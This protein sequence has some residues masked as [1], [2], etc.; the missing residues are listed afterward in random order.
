LS[1][2][3]ILLFFQSFTLFVHGINKKI[4]FLFN[5]FEI[6]DIILS[7]ESL[8]FSDSNIRFKLN[9]V[10]LNLMI[11][12]HEIFELFLCFSDFSFKNVGLLFFG[13]VNFIDLVKFLFRFDSKSLCDIVIVMCFFVIHL[14][15]SKLLLRSVK[16]DTDFLFTF[17]N[18]FLFYFSFLQFQFECLFFFEELLIEKVLHRSIKWVIS[19][20]IFEIIFVLRSGHELF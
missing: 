15:G 10:S 8:N 3:N 7:S 14:V 13:I 2:K 5:F 11:M 1:S 17:L 12:S 20:Q 16:T 9:I 4:L 6:S 18:I 19:C